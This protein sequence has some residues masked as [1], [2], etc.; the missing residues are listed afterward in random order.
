M[1]IPKAISPSVRTPGLGLLINL[2]AGVSSPGSGASK[3]LLLASKRA[4]VGTIADDTDVRK[5]VSG[6]DEVK[7]LLGAGLPGHLAAKAIFA[8]HKLAQVDLV[9]PVEA[10]GV[11]ATITITFA[12]GPPSAART[13]LTDVAGREATISWDAGETDIAGA[14]KLRD[15]LNALGD[16]LPITWDNAAG[17]SAVVT[18]T[19]KLNGTMGNDTKVAVYVT[20]GAGGTVTPSAATFAG[21]TTESAIATA[22]TTVSPSEYDF[23]VNAA[24]GNTDIHTAASTTVP[25]R[26]KTHIDLYDGPGFNARLQ[27][28]IVGSTGSV[29]A[30]KLG[31]AQQ[32]YGPL[33]FVHAKEARSFGFEFAGAE[34]GA[35]AREIAIDPAVNRIEMPYRATLYGP[36]DLAADGPTDVQ[37]EDLLQN[38]V[39]PVTYTSTG[40]PQPKRPVTSY[41]KDT[42]GNPDKRLL[43]TSRIDGVY[44]VAKDLRI[45]LPQKYPNT[46]LSRDIE[47]GERP[48]PAGVVQEKH[49]RLFV[50]GRVAFWVQAGVVIADRWEEAVEDGEFICQVD[51]SD[52]TQLDL[53]VPLDIVRPFAKTSLVINHVGT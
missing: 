13:V 16:D 1:P 32:N 7:T 45:A 8:E 30:V 6:P 25:G 4:A 9:A 21:G 28:A 37:V 51:E 49:V 47:P 31:S 23:I 33:Q 15:A 19:W 22:L 17:A 48:P 52:D 53:V 35:R 39:T 41:F 29:T 12:A 10:A 3:I 42:G 43:D 14:T 50:I 34:A 44:A 38:G 5:A 18:G 27:R 2:L 46:K 36:K 24:T 20:G 26:L 40:T 11:A